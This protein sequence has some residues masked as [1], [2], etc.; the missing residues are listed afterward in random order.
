MGGYS[1][2]EQTRE[3]L[4]DAAG[5]LAAEFGFANVSTRAIA[6]KA[7]QNIGSIH[8]HFG[9]KDKLFEEVMRSALQRY[10]DNPISKILD[11]FAGRLDEPSVQ[12][13]AIRQIVH[14]SIICAF[15]LKERW[16]NERVLYQ[17]VHSKNPL[18][19]LLRRELID[20]DIKDMMRLLKHI[21]PDISEEDALL[22]IKILEGPVILHAQHFEESLSESRRSYTEEYLK[23][24]EDV[25][26]RSFQLY[27]GLPLDK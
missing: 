3:A 7:N 18:R 14:R 16:W 17:A 11:N 22:H 8:Y 27:W 19:D 12:S 21:K 2:S 10:R 15:G 23:K 6:E 25:L 5:E 24:L 26:V 20:P 4:I 9:G 1:N 13:E